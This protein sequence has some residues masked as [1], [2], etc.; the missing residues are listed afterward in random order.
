M[1]SAVL[2]ATLLASLGSAHV[3]AAQTTIDKSAEKQAGRERLI[4]KLHKERVFQKVVVPGNLPRLYVAPR[5]YTLD[6]DMKKNFVSVVYAY[7]FDGKNITDSVRI[8]DSKSGKEIG[9]FSLP[10]GLKLD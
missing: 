9:S 5:F 8:F 4:E 3:A 10:Q 2:V 7:Y 1:R 6:F